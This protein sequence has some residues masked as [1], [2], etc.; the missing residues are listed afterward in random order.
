MNS[1]FDRKEDLDILP[2]AIYPAMLAATTIS[3]CAEPDRANCPRHCVD[4]CNQKETVAATAPAMPKDP[5]FPNGYWQNEYDKLQLEVG[6]WK[7]LAE[8]HPMQECRHCG[9]LCAVN[10]DEKKNWYPLEKSAQPI[11]SPAAKDERAAF[12]AW[13]LSEMDES[14][15]FEQDGAYYDDLDVQKAWRSWQAHAPLF[16]QPEQSALTDSQILKIWSD[17]IPS[18]YQSS[19]DICKA[20]R[21]VIAASRKDYP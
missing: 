6:H 4:F 15:T 20:V 19:T 9:F 14:A 16:P 8:S 11:S 18:G 7:C 2:S 13:Y 17:E 21:A 12:E 5:D 1:S 10:P 3:D